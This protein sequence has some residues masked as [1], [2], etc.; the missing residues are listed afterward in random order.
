MPQPTAAPTRPGQGDDYV[1]RKIAQ[2]KTLEKQR[3][4]L[5]EKIGANRRQLRDMAATGDL[6][7][8]QVAWLDAFYP[9]KERGERRSK[10]E[11]E[12]TR[13]LREEARQDGA[14]S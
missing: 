1:S 2:A 4:E 10:D 5:Q 12:R 3:G 8:E 14:D 13:K 6:T 11:I 9:E 7:T